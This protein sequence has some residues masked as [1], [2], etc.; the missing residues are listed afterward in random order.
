MNYRDNEGIQYHLFD[1]SEGYYTLRIINT[2]GQV[3]SESFIPD[4]VA[5][6]LVETLEPIDPKEGA[7]YEN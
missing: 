7:K 5:E 1:E 3:V 4:F 6:A 2:Y